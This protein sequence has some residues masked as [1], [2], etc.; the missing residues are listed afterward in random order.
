MT[1]YLV[2]KTGNGRRARMNVQ[3]AIADFQRRENSL[4]SRNID[5][6]MD[7]IQSAA[8]D[9]SFGLLRKQLYEARTILS[10]ITFLGELMADKNAEL[11]AKLDEVQSTLDSVQQQVQDQKDAAQKAAD[12]QA[13]VIADLQS[14]LATG[15]AG[16]TEAQVD[17]AIT[18]LSS[19]EDDLRTT[20]ASTPPATGGGETE[21]PIGQG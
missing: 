5:T 19:I 20:V 1:P 8:V 18:R 10:I 9:Q 6:G 14:Q 21:V 15:P 3:M 12:A 13:A 4:F 11:T 2:W 7:M 16:L 17:A